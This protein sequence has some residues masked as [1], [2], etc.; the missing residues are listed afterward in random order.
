[1]SDLEPPRN[2]I[3]LGDLKEEI[4]EKEEMIAKLTG[5]VYMLNETMKK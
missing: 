4:Q 1:M 2:E 5:K 3:T